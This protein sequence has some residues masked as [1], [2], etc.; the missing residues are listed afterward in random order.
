MHL[1]YLRVAAL[2]LAIARDRVRQ[3]LTSRLLLRTT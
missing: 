2:I 3:G 1:N